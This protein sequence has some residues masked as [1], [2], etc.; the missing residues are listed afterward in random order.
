MKNQKSSDVNLKASAALSQNVGR[1]LARINPVAI[2]ALGAEIGG[3]V[4]VIGKQRTL[5]RR[6]PASMG[7]RGGA[8]GK[9]DVALDEP[10]TVETVTAQPAQPDPQDQRIVPSPTADGF[11]EPDSAD[12]G[13]CL[14]RLSVIEG[15]RI[16]L[17]HAM[18]LPIERHHLEAARPEL[19]K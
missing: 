15:D 1:V 14:D 16:E 9:A 18:L 11:S 13:T 12:T 19:K 5:C 4:D 7:A 2:L 10:V 6:L 8:R 3:R 17:D